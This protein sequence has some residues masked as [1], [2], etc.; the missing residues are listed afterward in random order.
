M[1]YLKDI[2]IETWIFLLAHVHSCTEG[3]RDVLE[4]P[5]GFDNWK[6]GGVTR[7]TILH[8]SS[9]TSNQ[10]ECLGSNVESE[11]M[12]E[13]YLELIYFKPASLFVLF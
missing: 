7:R 2:V 1:V 9:K 8:V 5:V 12:T 3:H 10:L 13:S 4:F 11:C 6:F